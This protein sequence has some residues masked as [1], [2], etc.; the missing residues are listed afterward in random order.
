MAT[1]VISDIHGQCDMFTALLNKIGLN[2]ED[3]LYILG[4]II[5]RG[6]DP[7]RTMLKLMEMPNVICIKGN[8]EVMAMDC[9]EYFVRESH[10]LSVMSMDDDFLDKLLL[11]QGNGCSTTMEQLLSIS[12]EEQKSVINYIQKMPA[13]QKI[14]VAGKE[15]L[16]VHGGLGDFYPEKQMEEYS[17][18]DL[19]WERPD[20]STPYYH[21][22]YVVTGHTPTQ[23]IKANPKPGYIFKGNNHIAIDCG[24]CWHDGRLAAIRLDD[25][26]E[27]YTERNESILC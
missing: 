7:I 10:D 23:L 18:F 21:D 15:Y 3:T 11:W 4:D 1:Y 16:L 22:V 17:L 25:Q 27:F 20:Y 6:P 14:T 13:Y 24:S 26:K 9:L 19:V 8:H 2:D 5:D 12:F